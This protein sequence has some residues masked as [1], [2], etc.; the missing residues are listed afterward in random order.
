MY[1]IFPL[2]FFLFNPPKTTEIKFQNIEII[3]HKQEPDLYGGRTG[4]LPLTGVSLIKKFEHFYAHAYPDPL[5][6]G[7]P[8]TIG[9]GSTTKLDGSKW[10]MGDVITKKAADDLLIY[11]LEHDYLPQLEEI[12]G[13]DSLN[14]RQR[15]ALLSFAYNLGANFY[16]DRRFHSISTVLNW[17]DWKHLKSVLILYRNPGTRVEE[18]LK[19]R[20]LTEAWL[21]F[22]L[23]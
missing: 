4:K 2:A 5:T 12:P 13:W 10:K 16:G 8:I 14:V 11:Q 23:H 21:F 3:I 7:D 19:R 18:G 1:E 17:R 9:W 15:G 20:R 6:M 22:Q